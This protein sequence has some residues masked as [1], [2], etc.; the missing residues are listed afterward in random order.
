MSGREM[1]FVGGSH[2]GKRIS[3]ADKLETVAITIADHS[4]KGRPLMKQVSY[5]RQRIIGAAQPFDIFL[6]EGLNGDDLITRLIEG[7]KK[8]E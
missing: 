2:D 6:F 1:L 4:R 8:D 5:L 3:V 7:Y